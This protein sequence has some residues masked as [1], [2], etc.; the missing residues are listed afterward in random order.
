MYSPLFLYTGIPPAGNQ[1]LKDLHPKK[2]QI[3]STL[4]GARH[5]R[6]CSSV[7]EAW[8]NMVNYFLYSQMFPQKQFLSNFE[9]EKKN[10]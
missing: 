9:F 4:K 8:K 6:F 7:Q 1:K 3:P 2:P 5:S 10:I